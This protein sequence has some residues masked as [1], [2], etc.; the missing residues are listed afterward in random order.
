[1]LRPLSQT[2]QL[3]RGRRHGMC[4]EDNGQQ[5][6][7]PTH[8][9]PTSPQLSPRQPGDSAHQTLKTTAQP[10]AGAPD[11]YLRVRAV[12]SL[13]RVPFP[14][15]Q[16]LGDTGTHSPSIRRR[17]ARRQGRAQPEEVRAT[18]VP[19]VLLPS[20]RWGT[21]SLKRPHVR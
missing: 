7:P 16:P 6:R 13:H 2:E 20:A 15:S 5:D 19:Q 9:L 21:P 1:M 8:D 12:W 17:H 18:F 10:G 3:S 4:W 11:P 14:W